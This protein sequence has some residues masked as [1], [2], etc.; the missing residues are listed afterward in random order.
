[1]IVAKADAGSGSVQELWGGQTLDIDEGK[2]ACAIPPEETNY[3][4]TD[5]GFNVNEKVVLGQTKY[6]PHNR[7]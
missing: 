4:K 5:T 1:V 2:R 6:T 3:S 7:K